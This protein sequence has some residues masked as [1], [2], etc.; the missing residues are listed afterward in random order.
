MLVP[1]APA[2]LIEQTRLS[3]CYCPGHALF[4]VY[5]MLYECAAIVQR[6]GA[7]WFAGGQTNLH[8]GSRSCIT[9]RAVLSNEQL[10]VWWRIQPGCADR[11]YEED[12][13]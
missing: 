4:H 3:F 1:E 6:Q 10:G 11:S 2:Q 12:H 9:A 7:K 8:N 13:E 5:L